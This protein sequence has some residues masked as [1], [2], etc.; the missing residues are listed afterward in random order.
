LMQGQT[1][2]LSALVADV[3]FYKK[4]ISGE[5]PSLAADANTSVILLWF[6]YKENRS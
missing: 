6:T 3:I 1:L 2:F 5:W 4:K